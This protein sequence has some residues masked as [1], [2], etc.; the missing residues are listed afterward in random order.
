MFPHSTH[1]TQDQ[2]N[3]KITSCQS[4]AGQGSTTFQVCFTFGQS[5]TKHE[6]IQSFCHTT[7]KLITGKPWKV[8]IAKGNQA[9]RLGQF[10]KK[11]KT[12]S[13]S[14]KSSS[15][16]G[17]KGNTQFLGIYGPRY[18]TFFSWCSFAK[19]WRIDSSDSHEFPSSDT[20]NSEASASVTTE[21]FWKSFLRN[22]VAVDGFKRQ[23]QLRFG[24]STLCHH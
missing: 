8:E 24:G 3:I 15:D 22:I 21:S 6:D 16:S 5:H 9:W 12:S 7:S 20:W 4:F 19:I 14:P 2:L 11:K 1:S 13:W 17:P 10:F 18:G 23:A